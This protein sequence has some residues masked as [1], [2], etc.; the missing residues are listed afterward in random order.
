MNK[1]KKIVLILFICLLNILILSF[2]LIYPISISL[3]TSVF[4]QIP[5]YFWLV[6]IISPFLLYAIAKTSRNKL[7]LIIC[8][9]F[10]FFIFYSFGLYFISHPTTSDIG[11]AT[12]LQ[13]LLTYITHIGAS[14]I[15][16]EGYLQFPVYFFFSKIFSSILGIAPILTLNLGFI[17]LISL[18]PVF[19]TLFYKN[20]KN[21]ANTEK[22]FIIPALYFTLSYYF[23]NDQFVPQFL[24]LVYLIILFGCYNK[25][26]KTENRLFFVFIVFFY[27]LTVFSHSFIFLF[28]PIAILVEYIWTEYVLRRKNVISYEMIIMLFAIP[29]I[30][31]YV[32]L[33]KIRTVSIFGGSSKIF[34]Y[35]FSQST[36]TGSGF[37]IRPLYHLVPEFYDQVFTF[38]SKGVVA[39]AFIIVTIGFLF[40]L[41][42]KK[43]IT[44]LGIIIGTFSWFIMGFFK[45]VLGQRALQIAPLALSSQFK[46]PHKIFSYLSKIIIVFILIF[47]FLGVANSLINESI[48]GE[49]LIQDNEENI[50]GKFLDNHLDN[51][52]NILVSQNA[53]P[54]GIDPNGIHYGLKFITNISRIHL[55]DFIVISPKFLLGN[56]YYNIQLPINSE[57]FVIYNS[58]NIEIISS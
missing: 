40:Y 48:A 24:A 13:E 3:N 22:Y 23:L 29:S 57:D 10:Y 19:L 55:L 7:V 54:T 36:P 6:I 47:P 42:E 58:R 32:Y 39:G 52:S 14:E 15:S 18:F 4:F 17:S 53:Y 12:M 51:V 26:R 16:V 33:E 44:D 2:K 50:A 37:Q 8:A 41:L 56:M 46:H 35:I 9:M 30:Y 20:R 28:F 11:G 1:V 49:R 34:D 45:I 27:T 38:M 21:I 5:L 25:Y 43:R 31:S